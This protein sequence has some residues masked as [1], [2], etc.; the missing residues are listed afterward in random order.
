VVVFKDLVTLQR[1]PLFVTAAIGFGNR[2]RPRLSQI[3]VS[4]SAEI[5][6]SNRQF[7]ENEATD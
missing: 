3:K 5:V 7:P 2:N 6:S 4:R 1:Q